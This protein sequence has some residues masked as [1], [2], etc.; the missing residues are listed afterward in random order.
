MLLISLEPCQVVEK[1]PVQFHI[2]HLFG[3]SCYTTHLFRGA[4]FLLPEIKY[5]YVVKC[6]KE[7]AL[8]IGIQ[9]TL[10]IISSSC[11]VK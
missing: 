7:R 1:A 6:L 10:T 11:I 8:D 4:Y 2:Y 3:G 9:R 5:M